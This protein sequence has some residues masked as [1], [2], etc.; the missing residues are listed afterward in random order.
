MAAIH[1]A[2]DH[3]ANRIAQYRAYLNEL[4]TIGLSFPLPVKDVPRFESLNVDIA[5][6]VL[7]F[8]D[9]ELIPLYISPHRNRK[10]TVH[11]LL[12][13]DQETQHYTLIKNLSRLV[14]GRTKHDGQTFVCPY[15]FHCFRY[16]PTLE[17]HIP[18]CSTHTP[19]SVT[20]PTEGGQ[21]AVLH[22]KATQKEFP[23]PYVLYVDFESFLTPSAGKEDSVGEH[24]PS[25]FCCLK[26][27]KVDDEIFEPFI[28]S[29]PNVMSKFYEHV[30]REQET[31]CAKLDLQKD[32]I[33]LTDREKFDY[34]NASTCSNCQNSFD[35]SSRV[36]VRHHC[37][38][39][40]RFLGAVCAKCNLQLKYR[41]RKR[42]DNR[43]DEFFIPVF[44]HNMKN[45]DSHL[46]I[47]GYE[48]GVSLKSDISVIPSNTEKFIAFQIGKLR[49]LDSYQ[50]LAASLDKLVNILSA[51][52]FKFTSKFS[53]ST[54]L[55]KQKGVYPY[56]YM[57]DKSK[58]DEPRL[59][60]KD[61][62]YSAL[63]ETDITD[64]DYDRAHDLS[65]IHI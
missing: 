38:T 14:A 27:S 60:P 33:P 21:D 22:Y 62:F 29:G 2:T 58:F 7:T 10:H 40:G 26:V 12:L 52:A 15:C 19:Q 43:N 55:T 1:P 28:Y 4:N 30:Y 36:K 50:F 48:R 16:Q 23:V 6:N 37:H 24:V 61:K 39:T 31:I 45:Y 20:Y 8:E 57:T 46:I 51:D 59:P 56:E 41:K 9:R 54:H 3:H 49:F 65:L 53:P 35:K 18:D 32:M 25:G 42:P 5:V 11:L 34:R 13:T 64:E 47:K 63:T 17:K 44:A